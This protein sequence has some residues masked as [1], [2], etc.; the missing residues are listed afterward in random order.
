[1]QNLV[2]ERRGSA[3]APLQIHTAAGEAAGGDLS[4]V[5]RVAAG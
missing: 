2:H 1:V 4:T 5:A 3:P